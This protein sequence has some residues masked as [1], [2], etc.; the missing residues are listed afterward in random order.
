M[1]LFKAA[2]MDQHLPKT[3]LAWEDMLNVIEGDT[4]QC[5]MHAV[6]ASLQIRFDRASDEKVVEAQ[7]GK[8]NYLE[9]MVRDRM[10]WRL[11]D[12]ASPVSL[13]VVASHGKRVKSLPLVT[14]GRVPDSLPLFKPLVIDKQEGRIYEG[15]W[16]MEDF[17]RNDQG[18][19][20]TLCDGNSNAGT[21]K[22]ATRVGKGKIADVNGDDDDVRTISSTVST[23][24]ERAE[25]G[26]GMVNENVESVL[27]TPPHRPLVSTKAEREWANFCTDGF[28]RS[29]YALC[30]ASGGCVCYDSHLY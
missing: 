5:D 20:D 10:R 2:K 13:N 3:P 4:E 21:S 9:E 25:T 7:F 18:D 17:D 22:M 26:L 1:D 8:Y 11:Y 14:E 28:S 23:L 12:I 19:E 16:G 27:M 30:G 15:T 24:Y 29:K 6:R